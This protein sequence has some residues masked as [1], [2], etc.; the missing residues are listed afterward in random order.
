M[1]VTGRSSRLDLACEPS[2]VHFAKS[3]TEDILKQWRMPEEVSYDALTVVTE[4]TSNAVRYAGCPAV[5]FDPEQG[6]P[7]TVRRC[8]V[9]LWVTNTRL[10]VGVWDESLSPPVLQPISDDAEGGRG[11]RVVAGLSEGLWGHAR[12]KAPGKIVWAALPLPVEYRRRLSAIG[13]LS[14]G[15]LEAASA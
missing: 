6:Q 11:I 3:H 1:D 10:Y 8:A 2:A 13:S 5:P 9:S 7:P 4:L 14:Q 12:T 15:F